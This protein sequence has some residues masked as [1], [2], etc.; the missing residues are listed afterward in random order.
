MFLTIPTNLLNLFLSG[1]TLL[2]FCLCLQHFYSLYLLAF[3]WIM[4]S[5][6]FRLPPA[7]LF[8]FPFLIGVAGAITYF[9]QSWS[10]PYLVGLF[11]CSIFFTKWTGLTPATKPMESITGIKKNDHPIAEKDCWHFALKKMWKL[12]GKI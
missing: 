3:C 4:L 5:F 11:C 1:I 9:L 6:N 8:S 12:T 7:L 10:I 2:L